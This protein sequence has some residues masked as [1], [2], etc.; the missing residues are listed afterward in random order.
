MRYSLLNFLACPSSK[1]ALV[2]LS[3]KENPLVLPHVRQLSPATRANQPGAVVGPSPVFKRESELTKAL[4]SEACDPA[5]P[6]RNYEV[7]VE[8]GVLVCADNG[9]W[10]PIRN[11]IPELLPDHLRDF[12]RDFAFLDSVRASIPDAIY[13]LLNDRAIFSMA[14]KED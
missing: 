7:M 8:E 4:R 13:R 9:R 11:F 2:C 10:Y 12:D 6:A 1:T 5:P 14:K 3:T